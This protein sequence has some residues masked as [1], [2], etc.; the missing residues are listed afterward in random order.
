[1]DLVPV[2]CIRNCFSCYANFSAGAAG[3]NIFEWK[4][5][6]LFK[7]SSHQLDDGDQLS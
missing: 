6:L 7:I 2:D 1:M 3:K 5:R 4:L